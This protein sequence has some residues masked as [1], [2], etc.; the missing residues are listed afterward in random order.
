[1]NETAAETLCINVL[2]ALIGLSYPIFLQIITTLDTK[3]DSVRIM[4]RFKQEAAFR[5]F[6]IA[7]VVLFAIMIY[8]PFAPP[9]P[10]GF[11]SYIFVHSARIIA[12]V[13]LTL[14]FLSLIWMVRVTLVYFEPI[15][16]QQRIAG[17][18]KE[19]YNDRERYGIFLDLLKF[20]MKAE[21]FQLF[22]NCNTTYG[23]CI[24]LCQ[25]T[26]EES[27]RKNPTNEEI[28]RLYVK[29]PD[30]IYNTVS[31]ITRLSI[32][33]KS[34][35][36]YIAN[37]VNFIVS[38]FERFGN[39]LLSKE[40]F[41]NLWC[42]S[43]SIARNGDN[44]W[45][46]DYWTYALQMAEYTMDNRAFNYS[47]SDNLRSCYEK[48]RQ[49]FIDQH[50]VFCAY[51]LNKN[52][53]EVIDEILSLKISS[54][55][56]NTLIPDSLEKAIGFIKRI[57]SFPQGIFTLAQAFPFFETKGIGDADFI[58][59]CCIRYFLY[60]LLSKVDNSDSYVEDS[61]FSHSSS[62]RKDKEIIDRIR[63]ILYD[64]LIYFES[65]G[66]KRSMLTQQID[67]KLRFLSE[68]IEAGIKK[69][70]D[71]QTITEENISQLNNACESLYLETVSKYPSSYTDASDWQTVLLQFRTDCEI[72][73]EVL[74]IF[75]EE[76]FNGLPPKIN[77]SF[78]HYL[79]KRYLGQLYSPI[80]TYNV[81]FS[82]INKA[83]DQL[84][85]SSDYAIIG[86]GG[87]DSQND[88]RIQYQLIG[89]EASIYIM[90]SHQLIK[91]NDEVKS[92]VRVESLNAASYLITFNCD[93]NLSVPPQLRFIRL[94]II[95]S[96]FDGRES[97]LSLIPHLS[98][99][100]P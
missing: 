99:L 33:L 73:K 56:R 94:R 5:C 57:E 67:E 63:Q 72:S 7:V 19:L 68:K 37:P 12:I 24:G 80:K 62:D 71:N 6:S 50:Y 77:S 40:S 41:Q 81:D 45:I 82:E 26:A 35:N 27:F 16:L 89:S 34:S 36:P 15:K 20:S 23:K 17:K 47:I 25:N 46:L 85:T 64:N 31:E 21:N 22:L 97:Q 9:A 95:N 2:A 18:S 32:K 49:Y 86:S 10:C 65:L 78:A 93:L 1:M 44:D 48:E 88:S 66:F 83:L 84:A 13:W 30:F 69:D 28:E 53:K 51:L 58:E 59:G 100:L 98:T 3:Y 74:Y 55:S 11:S 54:S 90:N 92:E 70:I 96:L 79:A 43:L 4:Q 76:A 61:I 60:C 39:S 52:R 29:F 91:V 87:I 38:L 8:V 42:N 14:T 75:G